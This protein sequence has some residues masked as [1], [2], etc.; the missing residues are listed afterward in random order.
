MTTRNEWTK[1]YEKAV[2]AW[3]AAQCEAPVAETTLPDLDLDL[4][5]EVEANLPDLDLI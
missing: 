5:E 4:V 2:A 3:A 1:G